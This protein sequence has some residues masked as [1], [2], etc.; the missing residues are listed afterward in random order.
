MKLFGQ[1]SK[2][3]SAITMILVTL[4]VFTWLQSSPIF[5][6]PDSFYHTKITGMNRDFGMLDTFPWTQSSL[7]KVVFIDHHFLYHVILTPFVSLTNP[8]IGLKL[9]TIIFATFSILAIMWLIIK[10]KSP[11]TWV[12]LIFLL[13]NS[14]L[15]FRLSLGKTPSLAIGITFIAWY[16]IVKKKYLVLFFWSWFFVWFYSA[17]PLI[18]IMIGAATVVEAIAD[19]Y[20]K[21]KNNGTTLKKF[22]GLIWTN[23]WNHKNK[24]LWLAGISGILTGIIINPYFPTNLIYLKQLFTMS[25]V[26]YYKFVAIGAEWYPW[27]IYELIEKIALP[28][29][30]WLIATIVMFL[31]LKKQTKLSWSSWLM[32]IIFFIYTAKARRQAEYLVPMAIISSALIFRDSLVGFSFKNWWKNINAWLPKPLQNKW[33]MIIFGIYLFIFLPIGFAK[34]PIA[35]RNGLNNGFNFEYMKPA[36]EWLQN[37][38]L[39]NDIIFHTNWSTFTMLFYNNTHNYYIT[40]LDQ[41]FMYEYDPEKYRLWVD[42]TTGQRS[43]IYDIAKYDFNAQWLLLEKKYSASLKY[44]NRD[45]RAEKVYQDDEVIIFKL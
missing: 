41:T 31:N 23:F 45:P 35:A 32:T 26:G 3:W 39:T 42:A 14:P 21:I 30:A 15:I 22:C 36:S 10:E 37:N 25:L 16:F 12:W 17:W 6:D 40:G 19:S 18:I 34:G 1:H 11:L 24:L 9:A 27:P 2:L 7:Y 13:T 38:T 28:F 5:A 20:E 8:L 43:D 33:F 4:A 29:L 44:L